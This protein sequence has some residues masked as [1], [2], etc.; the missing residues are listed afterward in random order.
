MAAPIVYPASA[1]ASPP[2]LAD[3]ELVDE[4]VA[5]VARN[6]KTLYKYRVHLEEFTGW[7]ERYGLSL[8]AAQRRDVARYLAY[9]KSDQRVW[10]DSRKRPIRRPLDRSSR[11]GVLAALRAFYRHCAVMDYIA[12]DPT[13]G[14]ET[15]KVTIRRGITL[16]REELRRFLDA[17]G[18]PR[19]RVQAYLE[20]Y[21][22]GRAGS[23]RDILWQDVDFERNV[24]HFNAKGATTRRSRCTR[25]CARRCFAGGRNSVRTP[26][27]T[28]SSPRRS[29]IRRRLGY[30]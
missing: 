19:C 27:V 9:L 16:T 29:Q 1:A 18:K 30:S 15:P 5:M 8:L 2:D 13:F 3:S 17:R 26:S 28:R 21:T 6:P 22:A 11:K 23:I 24:I 7:L 10:R 4:F 25:S 14:V 20:V 12:R